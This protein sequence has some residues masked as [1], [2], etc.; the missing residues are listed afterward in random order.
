MIVLVPASHFLWNADKLQTQATLF[1]AMDFLLL[2]Y[3]HVATTRRA[4]DFHRDAICTSYLQLTSLDRKGVFFSYRPNITALLFSSD[5][6][7]RLISCSPS[8]F[9]TGEPGRGSR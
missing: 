9:S 8:A 6:T 2:W 7:R 1:M 5:G 4:S 3:P